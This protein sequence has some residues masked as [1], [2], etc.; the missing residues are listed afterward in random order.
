M[1]VLDMLVIGI[2]ILSGL[3]A[4]ARG[5]VRECLS[6]VS[7]LGATAAAVYALPLLRPLADRYLPKGAIAD[8]AA[9]A[10]VFILTLIILTLITGRISKRVQ[11]S[12]LSALDRT[13]G[14]IFGLMRGVLLVAIG[15]LA[16]SFVLPK[17]GD[18]PQ[19]LAQ[20]KTAPLFASATQGLA[21]LLPASFRDRA[22]Q[23][24]PEPAVDNAFQ[25]A[26]RAYST[27]A[28]RPTQGNGVST[29][30]QQRLNQL[31]QQLDTGNTPPPPSDHTITV[32][33]PAVR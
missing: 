15:F 26:L 32:P 2:V 16:L 14:L 21:K 9:A 3:L 25:N 22:G 5:F 30:D 29:Q 24:N 33:A 19:W 20:S 7:W 18:R 1:N 28:Q 4:F 23:F 13:L 17:T 31:L 11:S 27:P 10:T 12:S 8:A 6:I